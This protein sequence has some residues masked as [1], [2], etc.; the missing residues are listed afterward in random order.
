MSAIFFR[1]AGHP[2]PGHT[3]LLAHLARASVAMMFLGSH[4]KVVLV[5]THLPLGDVS[6]SVTAD[7]V[8]SIIRMTDEG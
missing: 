6:K 4:W 2:F 8:L 3:E 1:A 5:T 7:R